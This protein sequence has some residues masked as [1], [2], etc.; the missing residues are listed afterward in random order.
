[1]TFFRFLPSSFFVPLRALFVP[2]YRN[3]SVGAAAELLISSCLLFLIDR[4]FERSFPLLRVFLVL[5]VFLFVFPTCVEHPAHFL[6]RRPK[7]AREIRVRDFAYLVPFRNNEVLPGLP[8]YGLSFDRD[9]LRRYHGSGLRYAC[10]RG[11]GSGC[12]CVHPAQ[13]KKT[14]FSEQTWKIEVSRFRCRSACLPGTTDSISP[15][16][17]VCSKQATRVLMERRKDN[18]RAHY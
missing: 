5:S 15:S 2:V 4:C 17:Q 11:R 12:V 13:K 7:S 6:V 3:A 9:F 16:L 1:M 8:R 10:G 14:E 18:F